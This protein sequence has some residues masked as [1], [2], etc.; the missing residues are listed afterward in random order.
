MYVSHFSFTTL[1]D[2]YTAQ[3]RNFKVQYNLTLY[4]IFLFTLLQ[5]YMHVF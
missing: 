2:L 1:L 3:F 4:N 5:L